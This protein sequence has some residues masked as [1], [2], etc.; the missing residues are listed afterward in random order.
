MDPKLDSSLA[1]LVDV[2]PLAA[3]VFARHGIEFCCGADRTLLS[4]CRIAGADPEKVAREISELEDQG[5]LPDEHWFAAPLASLLD[6]I[7]ERYHAPLL[8]EVAR[9]QRLARRLALVHRR[10]DAER[11]DAIH[12]TIRDLRVLLEAHLSVEEQSVFPGLRT[13]DETAISRLLASR[14]EEDEVGALLERLSA[15]TGGYRAEPGDRC[16]SRVALYAG[17]QALH[18]EMTRHIRLEHEVLQARL[19]AG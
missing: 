14:P 19:L 8:E 13:G 6:H 1:H 11:L 4:A 2:A 9:L 5:E 3:R 15:L 7:L 17:L 10:V 16:N 18:L 12:E